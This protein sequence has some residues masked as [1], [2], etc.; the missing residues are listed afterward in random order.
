MLI[1]YITLLNINGNFFA[2]NCS[3]LLTLLLNRSIAHV[4]TMCVSNLLQ[5][6]QRNANAFSY[7]R[8]QCEASF[9]LAAT[10]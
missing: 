10:V 7:Y 2:E 6:V 1:K 5:N 4:Q 8:V 9:C 3:T